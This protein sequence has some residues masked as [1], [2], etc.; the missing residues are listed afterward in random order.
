MSNIFLKGADI[1]F[2]D[3]IETEGGAFY[4][5]G[6]KK[7]VL[8]ILRDS[9]INSA[10][11]RLWNEPTF[12]YCNPK[13]TMMMAK[14][15]KQKGL[16][17]LLDFHYSDY[18]ADPGKQFM[19]KA[20]EKLSFPELVQAVK[21]FTRDIISDLKKQGTLPDMVQIGNEITNGMLWD[22]GRVDGQW[23]T[24]EQWRKLGDLIQAGI[25]GLREALEA[26]EKI[27][28]MIHLDRGGDNEGSRYFF[29]RMAKLGVDFDIIGLSYY[30]W[31]HGTLEQFKE[32]LND[33]E[34]RYKKD[35]VI[36][37]VAYPWTMTP[38]DDQPLIFNTEEWLQPGYPASAEGQAA[39][40]RTLMEVIRNVPNE[41]G[42]GLYYW[43]P[44]WIP[45]KR[46]WS[47]GHENNWSNLT[48]FDYSGE[49][50]SS[51]DVF[52]E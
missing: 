39:W 25:A 13:K 50:L 19:P 38:P 9:G 5:N 41:R 33:L 30:P 17:F 16:H 46:T 43:E 32:N 22:A 23:N 51:L 27:P 37:E 12:D 24:E 48:M 40:L 7:D 44:C 34:A 28:V 8:D 4:E 47:V 36:A 18:W 29:D 31:W 42:A 49:K 2:V 3:E 15:I 52:K 1:S 35:I 10:R 26:D 45:S 20:W 11:L 21:G 14:R 6:Q